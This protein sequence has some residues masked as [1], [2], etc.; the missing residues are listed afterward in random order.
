MC[1]C[2]S[3][4]APQFSLDLPLCS[5]TEVQLP[6]SASATATEAVQTVL[7]TLQLTGTYSQQGI[8]CALMDVTSRSRGEGS[9]AHSRN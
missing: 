1:V 4:N 7:A 3:L 9:Y 2:I 6:L 8:Q 5:E